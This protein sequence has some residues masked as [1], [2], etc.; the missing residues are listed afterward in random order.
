MIDSVR[1]GCEI[2]A[3]SIGKIIM[4]KMLVVVIAL[5]FLGNTGLAQ[6]KRH[7]RILPQTN[8]LYPAKRIPWKGPTTIKDV[9]LKFLATLYGDVSNPNGIAVPDDVIQN[10]DLS[11]DGNT[12]ACAYFPAILIIWDTQTGAR[13]K[14]IELDKAGFGDVAFSPDGTIF[15]TAPGSFAEE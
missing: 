2:G 8:G 15:V 6:S 9:K 14:E 1:F 10:F 13:K 7:K 5:C 4:R 12:L 11:P 3:H